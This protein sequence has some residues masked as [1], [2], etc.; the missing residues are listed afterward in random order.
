VRPVLHADDEAFVAGLAPFLAS[1]KS[2]AARCHALF[3]PLTAESVRA[4]GLPFDEATLNEACG[5]AGS[6]YDSAMQT[7]ANHDRATDVLLTHVARV[8]DDLDYTRR[9]LHD[10]FDEQVNARKHVHDAL[11]AVDAAMIEW[12][13][14]IPMGYTAGAAQPDP[15]MWSR[16]V[17]NDGQSLPLLRML[18]GQLA[19]NQGFSKEMVRS[20][21]LD[22]FVRV[23]RRPVEARSALV[24]APADPA[25]R[26]ARQAYLD[27]CVRYL[28][29]YTSVL[30]AFAQGKVPDQS[31]HAARVADADRAL[32]EFKRAW[33]Q[34]RARVGGTGG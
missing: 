14:A 8:A 24:T 32:D 2:S 21:M 28:D 27:A 1:V 20:R 30:D 7:Y 26:A 33:A 25:E 17:E 15:G 4:H 29:V 3:D 22:S 6:L 16:E 18:Y 9:A 11:A 34:E 31:T 23:A 5:E 19:F 10:S 13:S 12:S